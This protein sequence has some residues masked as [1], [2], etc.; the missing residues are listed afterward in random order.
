MLT[1]GLI[2]SNSNEWRT[3]Q[4]LFNQLDKE[5]QFTLDPCSTDNNALC[6]NHFTQED[7]GLTQ[8]WG[9]YRCF[10]NPPYGREIGLWVRKAYEESLKPDTLCVLLIPARTDTSYWHDWIFGKARE[11]RFIRG[12]VRFRLGE[13][14]NSPA[15]FP[16][17]I[18]I[19]GSISSPY[20]WA[21]C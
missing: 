6:P 3:P 20:S 18:V 16:S 21:V 10:V 19:F 13:N 15:P 12:R 9:G 5:F 2:S 11:I 4:D 1:S 14:T 7:D 8:S 17:A